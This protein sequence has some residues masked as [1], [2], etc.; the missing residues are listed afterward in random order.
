MSVFL[1]CYQSSRVK[2]GFRVR[3]KACPNIC[4]YSKRQDPRTTFLVSYTQ[5]GITLCDFYQTSVSGPSLHKG[6]PREPW[7][8]S[9]A[10]VKGQAAMDIL[11]N[12]EQRWNKQIGPSLLIPIRSIPELSNQPNTASTDRDWNV[13]VSRSIDH[14]SA[15]HFPRNMTV[16]RSIHENEAYVEAIRRADRFI[17]IEN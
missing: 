7:H 10:R 6:G 11:N 3:Q 2:K 16:E 8:Y 4:N 9:H 12:F 17:Y 1:T 13:Q 14:V 15:Y 5:Y